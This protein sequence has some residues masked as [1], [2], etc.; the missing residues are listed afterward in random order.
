MTTAITRIPLSASTDG[1]PIKVVQT[2]TAGTTIHTAQA[3]VA[4]GNMDC[5]NIYAC[6][7]S[8]SDVILTMECWGTTSPD[9]LVKRTIPAGETVAVPVPAGRNGLVLRA[10]A[11]AGNVITISGWVD[12]IVVT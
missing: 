5:P 12:R 1:R 2:A 9:D 3:S 11:S 4:S 7:T 6:N 10:F 8:S